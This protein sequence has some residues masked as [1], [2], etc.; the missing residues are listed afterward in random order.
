M[1]SSLK[2]NS[3][4]YLF[5]MRKGLYHQLF[6]KAFPKTKLDIHLKPKF[7]VNRTHCAR[8]FLSL[9]IFDSCFIKVLVKK[10]FK[11][12]FF[13]SWIIFLKL[14]QG[15][16]AINL[17]NV[18]ILFVFLSINFNN[19]QFSLLFLR[20]FSWQRGGKIRDSIRLN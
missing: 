11:F 12:F 14:S 15:E 10:I 3:N 6:T 19:L 1:T 5:Y 18:W 20:I 7:Y 13:F 8:E 2:I 9:G 16:L 17:N 4:G